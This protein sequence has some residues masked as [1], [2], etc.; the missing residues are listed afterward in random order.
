[1]S[2]EPDNQR[3]A[4]LRRGWLRHGNPPGDFMGRSA[5]R[6]E[7]P[8]WSALRLPNHAQRPRRLHGGLSTG[9]RTPEGLEAIRRSRTIHGFYSAASVLER[10]AGRRAVREIQRLLQM[11][12]Q[13]E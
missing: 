6:G 13:C 9:P 2:A 4:A 7:E 11:A 5:L 3:P 1:M 12:W 10:R 8:S